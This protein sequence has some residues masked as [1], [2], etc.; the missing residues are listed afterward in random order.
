LAFAPFVGAGTYQV[1][2]VFRAST[3]VL[4]APATTTVT[5]VVAA[6]CTS[7]LQLFAPVVVPGPV[8][9]TGAY[10]LSTV[11]IYPPTTAAHI[12]LPF[13]IT[14][15]GPL[16]PP[17]LTPLVT[18]PFI[19]PSTQLFPA[20]VGELGR[21]IYLVGSYVPSVETVGSW[22]TTIGMEGSI[23]VAI[24]MIGSSTAAIESEGAYVP[25]IEVIGGVV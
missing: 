1:G 4:F 13:A 11:Q 21:R 17:S 9:Q 3:V 5:A 12:S 10:I 24:D 20:M 18:V 15:V 8:S 25:A 19:S 22:T 16:F 2:G 7:T 14:Q 23:T 6:H